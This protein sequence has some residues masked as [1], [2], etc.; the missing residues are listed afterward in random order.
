MEKRIGCII[1]RVLA[2]AVVAPLPPAANPTRRNCSLSVYNRTAWLY[3]HCFKCQANRSACL[4]EV[5]ECFTVFVDAIGPQHS[6]LG[7]FLYAKAK[8]IIL[9]SL[10]SPALIDI[11]ADSRQNTAMM[12]NDSVLA[13]PAYLGLCG[14]MRAQGKSL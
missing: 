2:M 1:E 10:H 4:P 6:L 3:K 11:L 13:L 8:P 5:L 7:T 12:A 9:L 14:K